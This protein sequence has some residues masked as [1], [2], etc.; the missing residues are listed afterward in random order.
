MVYEGIKVICFE[1]GYYGHG[2]DNCP[3]N[4]K[5]KAQASEAIEPES[6]IDVHSP[7]SKAIDIKNLVGNRT[8]QVVGVAV[9]AG[10]NTTRRVLIFMD[11]GCY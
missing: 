1:C 2:R 7:N 8:E 10:S 3:L 4:E 5:V 9:S 6:M 11:N